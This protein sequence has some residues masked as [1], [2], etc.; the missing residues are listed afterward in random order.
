MAFKF[1]VQCGF[2]FIFYYNSG[3][4]ATA[5]PHRQIILPRRMRSLTHNTMV[6]RLVWVVVGLV[7]DQ[8]KTGQ[9]TG[10]DVRRWTVQDSTGHDRTTEQRYSLGAFKIHFKK[11]Y[12]AWNLYHYALNLST[13][14]YSSSRLGMMTSWLRVLSLCKEKWSCENSFIS[15]DVQ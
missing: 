6:E 1:Y 5:P 13:L 9:N 8:Y 3:R 14:N 4:N 10:Q 7:A 15:Q 2:I 12:Y 11:I